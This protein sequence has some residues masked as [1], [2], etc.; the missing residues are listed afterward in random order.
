[1]AR[2]P[3][4]APDQPDPMARTP[5][6]AGL[7]QSHPMARP[8]ARSAPRSIT[9]RPAIEA[10]L[11]A[12]LALYRELHPDDPPLARADATT[13]WTSIATQTGRTILVATVATPS[14]ALTPTAQAPPNTAP[15]TTPP[16]APADSAGSAAP[17]MAAEPNP[18]TGPATS[19]AANR[20]REPGASTEAV[21]VRAAAAPVVVGT[22]DC[23][24]SPNLTRGGRPFLLV[25]NMVVGA[26]YRRLGIG[27]RL[28]AAAVDLAE[29]R[30]CYKAQLLSRDTRTEA[31][32]FYE[33]CGFRPTARGYRRY[34]P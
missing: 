22:V 25:E 5:A 17:R 1:M 16:T 18:P 13:I 14:P 23:L 33:A 28:L 24:V 26:A 32:A 31:H 15:T 12:L 9:V 19:G 27:A 7:D 10:D 8:P 11:P 4:A 3:A 21:E 20:S 2:P 30:N 6:E 29:A 34:L